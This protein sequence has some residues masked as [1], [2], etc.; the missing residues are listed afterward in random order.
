MGLGFAMSE[1]VL[2]RVITWIAIMSVTTIADAVGPGCAHRR[3][4]LLIVAVLRG[5]THA[6]LT[7]P[8]SAMASAIRTRR[9]WV[10]L[11]VGS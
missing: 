1:T 8:V 5:V 10:P 9:V 7:A 2:G 4:R 3:V 11:L 6:Q